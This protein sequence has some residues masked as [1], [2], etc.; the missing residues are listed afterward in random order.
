[1][2]QIRIVP[3]RVNVTWSAPGTWG[4]HVR[5]TKLMYS[6]NSLPSTCTVVH[7]QVYGIA[8]SGNHHHLWIVMMIVLL[9][10]SAAVLEFFETEYKETDSDSSTSG[11][12]GHHQEWEVRPQRVLMAV[13]IL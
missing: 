2:T 3:I 11:G 9:L 8:S 7:V 13:I 4:L 12:V 6:H 5:H 1:M 10:S